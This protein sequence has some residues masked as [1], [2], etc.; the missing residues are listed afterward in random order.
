MVKKGYCTYTK[1][2]IVL[3]FKLNVDVHGYFKNNY[4]NKKKIKLKN[5]YLIF[6]K[7][8]KM[9]IVYIYSL[10]FMFHKFFF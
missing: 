1:V 10:I 9:Y 3:V 5:K 6:F 2:L 8:V 4:K 7:Q